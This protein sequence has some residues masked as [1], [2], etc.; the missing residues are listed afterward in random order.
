MT[1]PFGGM[2]RLEA[3]VRGRVQGVGF[4][5]SVLEIARH[6]GLR[7]FAENKPDGSVFVLAE[8]LPDQL[9]DLEK[10]LRRGPSFAHV[11]AVEAD[12]STATGEFDGF[13][14]R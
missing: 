5:Y 2:Q 13:V 4:R 7:G 11:A 10:F 14:A 3:V 1:Q 8:G 6:A 9:D 12:R